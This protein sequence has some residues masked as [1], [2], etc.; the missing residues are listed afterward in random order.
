M[1]YFFLESSAIH[2]SSAVITGANAKHIKTVL[3]LKP[4]DII[5]IYDGE[6]FEYQSRIEEISNHRIH[7]NIISKHPSS[8]ESPVQITVGQAL[9]KGKKMDDLIRHLTEL[10]VSM[11]IPF[12][13]KRSVPDPDGQRL[14]KR[15]LRWETIARESLKQCRR[16]RAT[17]IGELSTFETLLTQSTHHDLNIIFYE[18]ASTGFEAEKSKKTTPIKKILIVIG[19]EG[20]FTSREIEMAKNAGFVTTG[21]GPRI[22]RAETATIAACS[23]VQYLFGDMGGGS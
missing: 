10:G 13:S 7:L 23:I 21:L 12:L 22:L 18:E 2:G 6:G 17:R 15:M 1:R 8:A 3:R 11:W 19:P 20:G 5:G 14:N 9:L 4:G 16:G